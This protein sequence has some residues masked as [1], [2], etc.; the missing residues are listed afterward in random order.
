MFEFFEEDHQ[1]N[2]E[3]NR[4]KPELN[5]LFSVSFLFLFSYFNFTYHKSS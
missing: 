1:V 3:I 4:W 2:E 5:F